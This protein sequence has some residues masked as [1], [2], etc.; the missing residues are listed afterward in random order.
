MYPALLEYDRSWIESRFLD[1]TA[2]QY[3][4]GTAVAAVASSTSM[5]GAPSMTLGAMLLVER[6]YVYTLDLVDLGRRPQDR[7]LERPLLVF[8][9][10]LGQ[11]AADAIIGACVVDYTIIFKAK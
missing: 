4:Y 1:L 3:Q 2:Q 8:E 11:I 7:N 6:L 5:R 9:Q 10:A